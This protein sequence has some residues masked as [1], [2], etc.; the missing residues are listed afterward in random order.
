M[1]NIPIVERALFLGCHQIAA[2]DLG[3]TGNPGADGQPQAQIFWLIVRQ[4]RSW[5]DQRHVTKK[6]VEQLGEFVD[7]RTAQASANERQALIFWDRMAELVKRRLQSAKFIQQEASEILDRRAVART[8]LAT[9][10][11][12]VSVGWSR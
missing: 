6:H 8:A 3:P 11:P 4:K 5:S 1:A 9:P 12:A 10:R 2:I 7:A